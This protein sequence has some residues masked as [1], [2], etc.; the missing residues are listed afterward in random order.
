MLDMPRLGS[1]IPLVAR[2]RE[3][4]RLRAAFEQAAAGS[5]AAVLIAGDAG[6]GKTRITEELTG[7]A[8]DAGALVLTGRCLDATETGLA[9]L[10]FAEALSQVPDRDRAVAGHPRL[11][12]LFPELALPDSPLP[13]TLVT[14]LPLPTGA[15]G[16]RGAAR[17]E[18][19]VG[20]LQLFDAV[21]GLLGELTGQRPVLLVL[22]DLHWADGSTRRLLSFLCA[23][24][25]GQRLLLIGTYRGDDLHRRHPLR[26][27]LAE[28]VRLAAVQRMELAPF[29]EAEAREFVVALAEDRL[30]DE[31]VRAVATRS[32]GNAFFA[33]ELLAAYDAHRGGLP[34]TLVDVLLTR[35]ERL[36][37]GAA[38]V[39]RVASVAGRRVPHPRLRAVAGLSDAEL[40]EALR[41]AV[42]HHILVPA[43]GEVYAF[44]HALLREAVYGD[45]LPGERVRLH[46]GYARLLAAEPD[47]RGVAAALAHHS[48]ESH[49]L[50]AALAASVTAAEEANRLG[51]PAEALEHVERALDLWHVVP[52]ADRPAGTDELTLL[53]RASWFA[54]TSGDPERSV[55]FARSAV[56]RAEEAADP[57]VTAEALRRLA[58]AL[59][60]LDG[61]EDEATGVIRRAW[62]L[63]KDCPPSYVK[64]WVLAVYAVIE[65]CAD[66]SDT[67]RE[68][69]ELAVRTARAA[70]AP[71]PE[72]DALT[73]LAALDETAGLVEQSRTLL[74][75]AMHRAMAAG[76]L[77]T[78]L[79][80]RHYLGINRYE[81]GLLDEAVRVV[82]EGVERAAG[83]GLTWSGYGLELRV[84]QVVTR[85]VT[86]DW[87]GA[88]A[89]AEPPGH[90]VSSTVSARLAAAGAQVLVARGAHAEAARLVT[91]LR[92]EWPRDLMIAFTMGWVG[93]ELACWQGRP[94]QG[95]A[96][97]D[98][99]LGHAGG[100]MA[101]IR[102]GAVGVAA[103]ADAA[104]RATARRDPDA[105]AAARTRGEEFAGIARRTATGLPRTGKLGPEGRAWLARAEAEA[106]RLS[107]PG[108][109]ALWQ[110][111]VEAFDYGAGYELAVCRWRLAGALLA[112]QRRDE[113]AAELRAAHETAVRLGARPLRDAVRR[114]ARRA[115]VTLTT[116]ESPAREV[117]DPFTPRERAV[118]AQVALGL[119]NRAI[120][121][122][123]FISEKT[124]SVHLSRIMAKLGAGNRAEAVAIAHE[125]GLLE[126][127]VPAP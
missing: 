23:R 10:P 104:A 24:L 28:L 79:R 6:V 9:Y 82:D 1:G 90:R 127:P 72:A 76:A 96:T 60:A 2:G 18:Q 39:V 101:G 13:G 91:E 98:A 41:E 78:E 42:Q 34:A 94:E 52:A 20:Q 57:E 4:D 116:D 49:A 109:P 44:R 110:A 26:P 73:T 120:G 29:G 117:V 33:E 64:A 47:G 15:G 48:R 56:R 31:A 51:A 65:R 84:M 113:A 32:E 3:L 77:T 71:G 5:A 27:L 7:L 124:V 25:R 83:T 122:E 69:A 89:A 107:G 59:S 62:E 75:E 108:D 8:R 119:T 92:P 12:S 38:Q 105:A 86:G 125:R 22:E 112:A 99:A 80:A 37:P 102:L 97:V 103:A 87:D 17:P 93:A 36:G 81:Q 40:E 115:R 95:I 118:I 123:L 61:K 35:T 100:L 74:V 21:H 114:L 19:D 45:L 30:P 66:R 58:K 11:A 126:Q 70:D 54:G 16:P 67:A 14:G 68:W 53:R 106:S 46:A 111:A 50:P 88:Q 121:A 85:Y 43:A 63:I 55:A